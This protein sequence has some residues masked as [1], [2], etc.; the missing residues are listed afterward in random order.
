MRGQRGAVFNH[1]KIYGA[2]TSWEAIE[3]YGCTRLAAVICDLRK[4]GY[5]IETVDQKSKNRFGEPTTYGRYVL[6][7]SGKDK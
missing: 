6:V 7:D 3:L 2:I 4:M 1:L 5:G